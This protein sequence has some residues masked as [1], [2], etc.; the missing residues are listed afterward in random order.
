M[1]IMDC[2]ALGTLVVN[3]EPIELIDV[4][5]KKE[6][7]A[8][9]IPGARSVPFGELAA[10][11]IFRSGR[12]TTERVYVIS[13]GGHARASLATGILRSAGCVNAVPV[14]GGM[15]DWVARGFPLQRKRFSSS[16]AAD[17]IARAALPV[18]G[19][20]VAVA[21]R[22]FTAAALLF[23]IAVVLNLRVNSSPPRRRQRAG[24]GLTHVVKAACIHS[25]KEEIA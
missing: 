18:M 3:H 12:P 20:G 5:S 2:S 24:R 17:F 14:D 11:R 16:S 23:A 19:A 25:E 6:F 10:T 8:M 1:K 22:E 21:L 7:A 13:A 4:R 15:K 9:H